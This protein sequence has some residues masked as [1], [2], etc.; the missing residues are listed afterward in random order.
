[1]SDA[2]LAFVEAN[3]DA[4]DVARAR[5]LLYGEPPPPKALAEI[6]AAQQAD[7][8]FAPDSAPHASTLVET[9]SRLDQLDD[10]PREAVLQVVEQA[11]DFVAVRQR[12]DGSWADDE[13]DEAMRI[14]LTASCGLR[15]GGDAG[16]GAA[17]P[18]AAA[19]DDHGRL[20]SFLQAHWLAVPVL[21]RAWHE[22]EAARICRYLA[23]E[24][25]ELDAGSLA[26]L[27]NALG[28]GEP[29]AADAQAR[30][31]PLQ[32]D[33]GSWAGDVQATLAAIRALL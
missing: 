10:L 3:G 4:L 20:P 33:D 18:L 16:R 14:Y 29:L 30:L 5:A 8:G 6:E 17:A 2:A 27:A 15:L 22:Q 32:R 28:P 9:C 13:A 23:T 26:W 12:D 25:D 31:P 11:L 1:M 19:V 24:I 7:G 21:R